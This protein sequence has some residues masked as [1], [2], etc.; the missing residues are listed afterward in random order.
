LTYFRRY[1]FCGARIEPGDRVIDRPIGRATCRRC[2]SIYRS[3]LRDL[4]REASQAGEPLSGR[5]REQIETAI[6]TGLL[7]RK[8]R[9]GYQL[10]GKAIRL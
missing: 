2:L 9:G 8:R 7:E 10:T 3:F 1:H 5:L 4:A 6:R